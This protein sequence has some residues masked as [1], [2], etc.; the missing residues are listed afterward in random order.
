M[1]NPWLVRTN[2]G[3]KIHHSTCRYAAKGA[4]WYFADNKSQDEIIQAISLPGLSVSTCRICKP[5]GDSGV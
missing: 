1:P 4:P 3:A 2:G 5:L